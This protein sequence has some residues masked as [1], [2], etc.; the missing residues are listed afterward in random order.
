MTRHRLPVAAIAAFGALC[1]L[2]SPTVLAEEAKAAAPNLDR[3][4]Q[5]VQQVCGGCHGGDGN[6]PTPANP[7]LAGQPADYI[8]LQLAH[9]KAGVRQNPIMQ[10]MA[11]PLSDD[12]MRA[13]GAYF[14]QQK[15]R[16]ITTAKNRD[17]VT[18]A[19][20][21]YRG[22]DAS[23]DIPACASCHGPDG[24]GIPR[25]YPRIG[26]Q[27][28]EYTYAQLKAFNGGTRGGAASGG[29]DPNGAIMA[30]IA[31]RLTDAQMQALAD[32]TAGLR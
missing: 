30:T 2:A 8:T 24:A 10:P 4:K 5:L 25:N 1:V 27:H 6:S 17:T 32:Y 28:A 19:Q 29:K 31:S 21:L 7:S 20:K 15:P 22:G 12:D 13:L 9:F 11:A 18:L 23:A 14:S 3:A 26:G 16:N